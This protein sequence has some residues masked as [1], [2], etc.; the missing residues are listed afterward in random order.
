MRQVSLVGAVDE[1]VGDYFPEF[2]NMLEE[3]PFLMVSALSH[4]CRTF[5]PV[6]TPTCQHLFDL[7]PACRT[8]PWGTFSSLQLQSPTESDDGPIMWVRPG[9]QMIPM[10]DMPKSPFKRKRCALPNFRS[11][12]TFSE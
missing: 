8:L 3:S 5:A 12:N 2:L 6:Q 11:F 10:A 9:E 7:P 4:S 1:E